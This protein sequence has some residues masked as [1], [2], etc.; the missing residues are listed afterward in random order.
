MLLKIHFIID[1]SRHKN[2]KKIDK[3]DRVLRAVQISGWAWSKANRGA[4]RKQEAGA[5]S[6]G[7]F[8]AAVPSSIW[9]YIQI[10]RL[11]LAF[12]LPCTAVSIF[13][14]IDSPI[15]CDILAR[16][17]L[18]VP[19]HNL[20]HRSAHN[21][22][23]WHKCTLNAYG[24]WFWIAPVKADGRIEFAGHDRPNIAD[25]SPK[26]MPIQL[27][28]TERKQRSIWYTHGEFNK[29]NFYHI[30][31]FLMRKY[32]PKLLWVRTKKPYSKLFTIE[33]KKKTL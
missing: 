11:P 3:G 12:Q 23:D 1:D 33:K 6:C 21:E 29:Y 7:V 4:R 26:E 22:R 13:I 9:P 5:A 32:R 30:F 19:M 28:H 31:D 10:W 2:V 18:H 15:W 14:Y 8:P 17:P 20:M 27:F 25:V 24:N 16:S